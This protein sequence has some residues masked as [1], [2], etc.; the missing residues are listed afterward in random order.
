[1]SVGK[2]VNYEKALQNALLAIKSL[3]AENDELK[4]LTSEPIAIVGIGCRLPGGSNTPEEYWRLLEEGRDATRDMPDGRWDLE[5]FYNPDPDAPGT[6]YTR[7]GGFL[8]NVDEFDANFF[9]ISPK[10]AAQ[11][12]PQQRLLLEVTWE[13]LEN[14]GQAPDELRDSKTGVF[15]GIAYTDFTQVQMA[16]S[17]GIDA[18]YGTGNLLSVAA[19]RISYTLGLQGPSVSLDT[20]CSSSLVSLHL[21]AQSLKNHECDMAL[22]GG[23]N[24]I[25]APQFGISYARARMLSRDGI[26]KAFDESADGFARGE[27][28]G[29]VV[30]K[31]LS[32]ARKNGDNIIATI[33]SSS[34]NHDGRSSGL[35][36][37]NG[38]SQQALLRDALER[39]KLEP[40]DVD[41]IEAHGTGTSLGDP[42]E[43]GA[44]GSVFGRGER[45][46]PL[47]LGTVK[48]NIGHLEAAAGIAGFI[49]VALSLKNKKLPANLHFHELNPKISLEEI[50]ALV[51][52]ELRNWETSSAGD[53]RIAGVSSFGIGGTNAHVIL[54]G[55]ADEEDSADSETVSASQEY[56]LLLPLSARSNASLVNY[57]DKFKSFLRGDE[58][59]LRDIAYTA[60]LK[61]S[62]HEHRLALVFRNK[63]EL[64]EQ[65]E[66]FER[67]APLQ[68]TFYNR[69]FRSTQHKPVFIFNGQGSQ[70]IGMGRELIE[71]EKIF[72]DAIEE[73][74]ELF[75]PL[76]GWSIS[77][78][79]KAD[80]SNSRLAETQVAQPAIFALQ[81][82]L[83]NFLRSRGVVPKATAGH[84]VGEIAA[85][86]IA[87][88]YTLEDAVK[89][90]YHRSRVMQK[91][92][93]IGKMAAI[94]LS[95]DELKQRLTK[96]N[97][98]LDIGAVNTYDSAV[99]SGDSETVISLVE[100]LKAD[101]V[102]CKLLDVNYAFHSRQMDSFLSEIKTS[103]AD[104]KPQKQEIP[105]YSTVTGKEHEGEQLDAEYWTGNVRGCVRFADT[106]RELAGKNFNLF[107]EL[108]P[109]PV[110][111]H[112]LDKLTGETEA[113]TFI[114]QSLIRDKS[115]LDKIYSTLGAIYVTGYNPDWA[116]IGENKDEREARMINLPNYAWDRQ[117]Y[118][119][120]VKPTGKTSFN[121]GATGGH[122]LLGD[123]FDTPMNEIVFQRHYDL[124][125]PQFLKE[126]IIFDKVILPGASNVSLVAQAVK[127]A[128]NKDKCEI[129]D[130]YFTRPF[131]ITSEAGR[132]MQL[133]LKP[134]GGDL[135]S[136]KVYSKDPDGF[137]WD[138]HCGGNVRIGGFEDKQ[139][140]FNPE[141]LKSN[142][143]ENFEKNAFYE[144]LAKRK[145]E[146]GP[147]FRWIDNAGRRDGESLCFLKQPPEIK[148]FGQ[149]QAYP[150]LVDSWLQL[151]LL[152]IPG[153]G[154]LKIFENTDEGE[155]YIPFN[156]GTVR[157]YNKAPAEAWCHVKNVTPI[158]EEKDLM[159]GD[160]LFFDESGKVFG[161]IIGFKF[162]K[163]T[164]ESLYPSE[165][166]SM[167]KMDYFE[168]VWEKRPL[169]N[170]T[171]SGEKAN[172]I[173]FSDESGLGEK[174]QEYVLQKGET[175]SIVYSGKKFSHKE[176]SFKV[177]PNRGGDFEKLFDASLD[178]DGENIVIHLWGLDNQDAGELELEDIKEDL[179]YSLNSGI[180]IIQ[181]V[182]RLASGKTRLAIITRDSRKVVRDDKVKG[183]S[184]A[185]LWGLG[186]VVLLEHPELNTLML[187]IESGESESGLK[188]IYDS[189]KSKQE[190]QQIALRNNESYV[191]R[192]KARTFADTGAGR[193]LPGETLELSENQTYLIT[194]GT[195]SLGLLTA[196]WLG[197]RGAKNIVLLSR[198]GGSSKSEEL[199]KKMR[200]GGIN[201]EVRKID[202]ADKVLLGKL[203]EDINSTLPPV[204]GVIHCA[205]LLRD[206]MLSNQSWNNFNRVFP[207]KVDGL[208]NL[209]HLTEK[210]PLDFF[211]IF[212]SVASMFGSSGQ[213]N[214]ASANA[215]L[216]SFSYYRHSL[217]LPATTINW[218]PW[219]DVGMAATDKKVEQNTSA[220]GMRML[221]PEAGMELLEKAILSNLP[222]VGVCLVEPDAFMKANAQL[223]IMWGLAGK[224]GI[225]PRKETLQ[226]SEDSKL[227]DRLKALPLDKAKISL[228]Q[229]IQEQITSVLGISSKTPLEGKLG[230]KDM[231][232]DSLVSVDLRNRLQKSLDIPLSPTLTFDYP[233]FETLT[234]HLSEKL[235]LSEKSKASQPAPVRL[236]PKQEKKPAVDSS[237]DDMSEDELARLLQEE[238]DELIRVT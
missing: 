107:V 138:E 188:F 114:V 116:T 179:H 13:A 199:V 51:N 89:I 157:L 145:V 229:H 234:I 112:Y 84:S 146:L 98:P 106:I 166:D 216:D 217:G 38:P 124:E 3:K 194:G 151:A 168:P 67:D 95:E 7:R 142:F 111:R 232:M 37:P 163:V 75:K 28:C 189:L 20:A 177:N 160:L 49:K 5:E 26:C 126:H 219:A 8:S 154:I 30:L 208:W 186:S 220:R 230:F 65:L 108:G 113:D 158:G 143:E 76:A 100:T 152:A 22:A 34:V 31:R 1:M 206:G 94:D 139:I 109:H 41:Y 162:R 40:A 200:D 18:Y 212:S 4:S 225:L 23:V 83:A 215:F 81:V 55:T 202:L 193:E 104:I 191:A 85:A 180:N 136:F 223:T 161:E 19:G 164:S 192:L 78:E 48:T 175:C 10:E 120:D 165:L 131:V 222:Q 156:L 169:E 70:W 68:G 197:R 172:W 54:E 132:I 155:V 47:L 36:V 236:D 79:L 39:A 137:T 141:D 148:S 209:H 176:N 147:T 15:V 45:A 182:S 61:R 130:I 62:H 69:S 159:G 71:K 184:S 134:E 185:P 125:N 32:D 150:T 80:E 231:G 129:S 121:Y 178:K 133:L 181:G 86:Y 101:G 52:T 88:I 90:I 183:L 87:G 233:N 12:D 190:E 235:K 6:A 73:I 128:F 25:L 118:W 173:I 50:P 66:A 117:L 140:E 14:A 214:Y 93:G 144:G 226:K 149:Y 127:E 17:K 153:G 91:A 110:L 60:A 195:G 205:G 213:G 198:S 228:E 102:R 196:E 53:S 35:T 2:E 42:I 9:G 27:G 237:D 96:M 187:D 92:T 57:V 56:P 97:I 170:D 11:M 63:D 72:R 99:V 201:V 64:L 203:F 119:P 74:D 103:L 221:E 77:E 122:P 33:R 174:L 218:G 58:V 105:F 227:V 46:Q 82:S 238:T 29:I 204:R 115:D 207:S 135:Y 224:T 21:A 211:V 16:D 171:R 24:L 59:S 167:E 123:R 43:V 210:E 44:I